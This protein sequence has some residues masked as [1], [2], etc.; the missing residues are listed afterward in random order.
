MIACKSLFK[1]S[2]PYI[3]LKFP[4]V[5]P[6]F[7]IYT[8]SNSSW[9]SCAVNPPPPRRSCCRWP[10]RCPAAPPRPTSDRVCSR[11]RTSPVAVTLVPRRPAHRRPCRHCSVAAAGRMTRHERC[12]RGA[13][14]K[15]E[16]LIH[17]DAAWNSHPIKLNKECDVLCVCVFF[18]R[19]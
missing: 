7:A 17:C 19:E 12:L 11:R 10:R 6:F 3:L 14:Q 18:T 13:G 5:L 9:R 8:Y 2:V 16:G 4:N 1:V 15:E